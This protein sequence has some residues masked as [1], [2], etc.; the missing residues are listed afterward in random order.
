MSDYKIVR[1]VLMI[2]PLFMATGSL[3]SMQ[4]T[5][6]GEVINRDSK[7]LL[8]RKCSENFKSFANNPTKVS[9]KNGKFNYTFLFDE[10]EAYELIF[11]DEFKNDNM[12]AIPF[13]PTNGVVEFKLYPQKEW[14]N[15]TIRG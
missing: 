6:K 13:F 4:C 9:I 3:A 5:I 7:V 11:E 1:I 12:I 2:L 15:N 14:E 8:I 10:F